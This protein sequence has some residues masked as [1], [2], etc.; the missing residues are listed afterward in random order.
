MGRV[1]LSMSMAS[2]L[3]I[4]KRGKRVTLNSLFLFLYFSRLFYRCFQ[5]SHSNT[6]SPTILCRYCMNVRCDGDVS[7][8]NQKKTVQGKQSH[9]TWMV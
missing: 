2:E 8:R 5:L 4:A 7:G 6:P 1:D 3:M 9:K